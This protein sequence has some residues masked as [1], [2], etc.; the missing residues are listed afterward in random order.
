MSAETS[1]SWTDKTW[2][3]VQGCDYE[4]PGCASCYAVPLLWRHM[5]NPKIGKRLE[6]VVAKNASGHL[7]FTG[8]VVLRDDRLD[9]PLKWKEPS[10]IFV[11]SHGDLFHPAVPDWFIDNVFAVMASCPR[12]TFQVLTKRAARMRDYLQKI[13]I[14]APARLKHYIDVTMAPSRA[15]RQ[16]LDPPMGEPDP[17]TPELRA[18]Y[19]RVEN[20]DWSF[21]R[22][23][24]PQRHWQRWPLR[25]VWLG[26]STEDQKRADLRIPD[27]M[28][29]P[30]AVRFLSCEPLLEGIDIAWALSRN[31]FEIG[32][33]FL[34][35]GRFSPGAETLRP[36]DL[37]ITGGESKQ[38]GKEPRRMD[39]AWD[40][41]LQNQ[42]KAAGVAF[43]RKQM[44]YV[45]AREMGLKDK[46]GA[47]PSEWPVELRVQ[48]MPV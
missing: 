45:L 25:N 16:A 27:L 23:G 15:A 20:H 29:T 41:W 46:A 8:K 32:A 44:G 28:A 1:I 26:V 9:W 13:E 43:H 7:H 42:C 37:V 14:E 48:E 2:P 4:S 18:L 21:L 22:R 31:V 3:I 10:K 6:G 17:P 36:I 12:H 30:A 39:R 19:D 33:G 34:K 5:H 40:E 11:P 24:L 38:P 35:R 47:D